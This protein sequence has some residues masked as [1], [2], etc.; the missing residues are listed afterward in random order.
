MNEKNHN[1]IHRI[2][3]TSIDIG[4]VASIFLNTHTP[5]NVSTL[6]MTAVAVPIFFGGAYY[7]SSYVTALVKDLRV[8]YSFDVQGFGAPKS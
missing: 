7:I 3:D 2:A 8:Y 1:I 5:E 4:L 6:E